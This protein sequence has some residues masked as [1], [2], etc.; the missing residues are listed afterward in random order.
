V[1]QEIFLTETARRAHVVLPATGYLEH[2]GTFI[3]GER[4]VQRV[5]RAVAPPDGARPDWEV[6]RDVATKL[7]ANRGFDT[8][9]DVMDEI[10]EI[11]PRLFGGVSYARLEGDG[12]QWPCPT[13]DHPGTDSVHV[14]G[15]LRG[16]GN[17]VAVDYEP[18]P[19]HGVADYP[20]M[21][22][23][24]RVLHQYNVG[25]MT[26][27]TPQ[28][29]FEPD[30]RLEIHP[31][32]AEALGADENASIGVTSRWGEIDVP[33]RITRRVPP[34]IV[35]LSFHQPETHT[36]RVVGPHLDP[37]SRCPQYKAT[38]VRLRAV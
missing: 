18:S 21:L 30:D 2:D 1:V 16:K 35:F 9:A 37:S 8:P 6:V 5:R 33:I 15:F 7:G 13:P 36:N 34:G 24:G 11:A 4:R 19:E 14:E 29:E 23:T 3:N 28:Q 22:V 20:W 25:T 38:A 17:L 31:A 26:R 12:L 10:A 32:D 27:R